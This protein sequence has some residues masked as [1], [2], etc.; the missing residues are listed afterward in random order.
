MATV[1]PVK[2]SKSQIASS[3]L[4]LLYVLAASHSGSTLT[5]LLLG[6]HS[7]LCTVGELKMTSI[8]E[9]KRYRCSCKALI[10]ECG[11]WQT[12]REEMCRRGHKKF[13]ID[14]SGTDVRTGAT[15]YVNRLLRPLCRS[16][17]LEMVRDLG[18]S[19]SPAWRQELP[20]IQQANVD[21]ISSIATVTG[22]EY[23]VDSSKIG[24]R[25]KY[26][27]HNPS[28]EIKVVRLVRDGRAVSLTYMDPVEFADAKDTSLRAGGL[29]GNRD[30]ERLSLEA[31]A[32]EWRRSNEEQEHLL[33]G[34]P[35]ER[36]I[37]LRYEDICAN[38]DAELAKAFAMLG[39]ASESVS[40]KFRRVEQHVIGNGMRLDDTNQIS[41]DDRWKRVFTAK[42]LETFAAVAGAMNRKLGYD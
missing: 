34:I 1:A 14:R 21:L 30:R 40:K 31:A 39:V 8:G 12:I 7:Q 36:Q 10:N 27:L 11:F 41:L 26:L 16:P 35:R 22:S 23:V 13:N 15:D 32:H 24:I 25:L 28:L 37:T 19:L 33:A 17:L 3:K 20:K 5:A 4:K 42:Q 18:L 29:G 9:L 2:S 38:P 6:S